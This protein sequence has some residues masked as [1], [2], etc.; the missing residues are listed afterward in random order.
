MGSD[1]FRPFAETRAWNWQQGCM[2]HWLRAPSARRRRAVPSGEGTLVVYNDREGERFVSVVCDALSG[3]VLRRLALPI[4]AL[5][6]DGRQAMTFN[7]SRLHSAPGTATPSP[8]PGSTS[9]SPETT[10]ST[11]WTWRPARSAW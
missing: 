8:T 11:T 5:S 7:F 4:Y 10:A 9:R 6:P 2:L 3:R 1:R